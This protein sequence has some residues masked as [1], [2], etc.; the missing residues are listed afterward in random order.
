MQMQR[1]SV[2]S[3][4]LVLCLATSA[5][6]GQEGTSTGGGGAL[7]AAPAAFSTYGAG[8]SGTGWTYGNDIIVP[9]SMATAFGNSNNNIPFSWNPTK[10]QQVFLGSEISFIGVLLGM[11]LRQDDQF[12]GYEAHVIEIEVTFGGSTLDPATLTPT[13]ANNFNSTTL[14]ARNV[15]ARRKFALPRM[16]L[17]LPANPAEFFI[18]I[19]FD[20]PLPF[21]LPAGQNLVVEVVNWG[22]TN[23]NAIFTYP[24]DAGSGVTTTR[25]YASGNPMATTGT[26]GVNYGHVIALKPAG[27]QPSIP[28]LYNTNLPR[29]GAS[30][31]FGLIGAKPSTAAILL[32]GH[33]NTTWVGLPLPFDL[34][35]A[36]APGCSLLASGQLLLAMP[37]A[38]GGDLPVTLPIPQHSAL[39]GASVYLQYLLL[40]PGVNAVGLVTSNGGHATLGN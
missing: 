34:T 38:G 22:N 26:L 1:I 23:N 13:F 36:G 27:N 15:F 4:P 35:P 29:L 25:L 6:A 21:V 7:P 9:A 11:G 31:H 40:D 33:S 28:R 5:L 19:P 16:P 2:T 24:L 37:V 8:C 32:I 30:F 39:D 10:Y 17:G 14:P 3:F 12:Q 18:T 20:L